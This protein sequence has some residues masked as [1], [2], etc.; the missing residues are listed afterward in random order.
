VKEDPIGG[1]HAPEREGGGEASWAGAREAG[2]P[3]AQG[4]KKRK[5][6]EAAAGL[7]GG[8]RKEEK[9][10]GGKGPVGL[11]PKERKEREKREKT[12]QKLL[13]LQMKFEFKE[14]QPKYQCKEH[15]MR[16]HM[17][18]P[19]FILY[20]KRI[21]YQKNPV[22]LLPIMSFNLFLYFAKFRVTNLPPLKGISSS[23]FGWASKELG[24]FCL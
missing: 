13:S 9:G 7:P 5:E 21:V 20:F 19:I 15:E 1:A 22:T 8:G 6:R 18:F 11:G 2:G 17:V 14:R 16:K 10:R 3:R 24:K 4:R 12:K 23:R